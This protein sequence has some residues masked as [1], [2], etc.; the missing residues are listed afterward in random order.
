[1]AGA[2]PTKPVKLVVPYGA[3]SSPDVIAR[4]MGERLAPRLG[5]PVIVENR[6]GAGGNTERAPWPRRLGDGYTFLISTRPPGLQHRAV[7][8]ASLRPLHGTAARRSGCRPGQHLRRAR[9]FRHQHAEGSVAAMK[10]EPGKFNFSSTGV[11]SCRS[12]RGVAQGEDGHLCR[13]H[14]Y[15]SSP[16]AILAVLQGDV[17]FA[18]VPAVR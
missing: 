18:C 1:M 6:V 17:Q 2:W 9:R 15:A 13:A 16:L 4:I 10:K 5:Q 12:W 14:P 8:Q 7:P 3:G 11:G